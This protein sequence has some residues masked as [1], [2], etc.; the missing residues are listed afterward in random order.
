M[1]LLLIIVISQF[2]ACQSDGDDGDDDTD[3]ND[4]SNDYAEKLAK[5]SES[6]LLKT[7]AD[8]HHKQQLKHQ[9]EQ[10]QTTTDDNSTLMKVTRVGR[11]VLSSITEGN[12]EKM[13]VGV[14]VQD[15]YFNGKV[16]VSF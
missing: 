8:Y 15:C 6:M 3:E 14:V 9:G 12:S 11:T 13:A 4:D 2:H 7:L 10:D 1:N 16:I 5:A